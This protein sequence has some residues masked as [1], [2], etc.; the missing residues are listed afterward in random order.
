M[1]QRIKR[2]WRL[3]DGYHY[4]IALSNCEIDVNFHWR[5][6]ISIRLFPWSL[7]WKEKEFTSFTKWHSVME[8]AWFCTRLFRITQSWQ[9]WRQR[10]FQVKFFKQKNKL[11]SVGFDLGISYVWDY[12]VPTELLSIVLATGS[13]NPYNAGFFYSAYLP[14][15]NEVAGR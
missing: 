10:L 4:V 15:A 1:F 9:Y 6:A 2:H 12:R 7:T 14:P 11:P 13:Q 8:H 5:F 3:H